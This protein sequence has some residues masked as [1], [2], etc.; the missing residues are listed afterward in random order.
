MTAAMLAL[1]P[2]FE[3][4]LPSELYAYRPGRNAQQAVVEVEELLFRGH[5]DVVDADLADYFSA[6]H[7][8]G[9]NRRRSRADPWPSEDRNRSRI[10]A[11]GGV[12]AHYLLLGGIDELARV[13]IQS[14]PD[15][16]ACGWLCAIH[17]RR[18][19]RGDPCLVVRHLAG[20]LFARRNRVAARPCGAAFD[21]A[22]TET[23]QHLDPCIPKSWATF[24]MTVYRQS[25]RYE[26]TVD[27]PA[28]ISRGVC[29]AEMDGVEIMERPLRL[30]ILDD[31]APRCS[32]S[33]G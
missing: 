24:E 7:T 2:I 30:R 4:D 25:A 16:A 1:E 32:L 27:N 19:R 18:R 29:F 21:C 12:A 11:V 14:A 10:R 22:P 6:V 3:A 20:W 15:N 26:I 31:G 23:S 13:S 8:P 5:P 9:V 33:R 28:E 17:H